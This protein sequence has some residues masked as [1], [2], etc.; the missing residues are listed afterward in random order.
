MDRQLDRWLDQWAIQLDR[1]PGCPAVGMMALF[2]SPPPRPAGLGGA[3]AM[4]FVNEVVSD[5]DIDRYDLPFAKGDGQYWTRD[6]DRD[7]YLWGGESGNPARDEEIEGKFHLYLAGTLLRI[8]LSLGEWSRDW[9][10][11]PYVV[12]WDGPV[13]IYPPD[14]AGL[15]RQQVIALLKEALIAYGSDGRDNKNVPD[16]LVRFGF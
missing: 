3:A 9:T 13:G 8:T 6:R 7:L 1:L 2:P 4:P 15:D 14:G 11:T 5:D 10:V 16:R 12:A